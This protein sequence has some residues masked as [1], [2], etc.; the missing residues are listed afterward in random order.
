MSVQRKCM[1]TVF[2]N[3]LGKKGS[4]EKMHLKVKF[5][6]DSFLLLFVCHFIDYI[7]IYHYLSTEHGF[8]LRGKITFLD[9]SISFI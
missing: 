1:L 9:Q 5:R 7:P 6:G 2:T 4:T 8:K 3:L